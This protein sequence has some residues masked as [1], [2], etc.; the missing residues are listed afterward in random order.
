[1]SRT[2]EITAYIIDE[3]PE[4]TREQVLNRMRFIAV[5]DEFSLGGLMALWDYLEEY[6]DSVGEELE[7]DVIGLCCNF[8]E[9]A[10]LAEFQEAYSDEYKT[11][12]DVEDRTAVIRIPDSDGFIILNF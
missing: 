10:N 11:L 9:Y 1:M 12:A 4:D 7:L 8:A 5:Q 6:E 3:L 2:I